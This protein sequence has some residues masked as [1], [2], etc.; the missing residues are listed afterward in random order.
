MKVAVAAAAALASSVALADPPTKADL[1]ACAAGKG[2]VC[3]DA[4]E[5]FLNDAKDE[6]KALEYYLK[7]C[8]LKVGKGCG[9]AG[10]MTVLGQGTS[11]DAKAGRTLREKAC[12][13]DDG[14]SCNDLG[15]S[16]SEGKDGAD[17]ID[18]VK[19]KGFY[20]KACKLKD[21]LGCFNLGNVFRVGEGVKIDLK[22]AFDNF[23]KSCDLDTAKGCTE[24]AIMYY[25]GKNVAKDKSK[26][27]ELLDKACK[28]GS[29]VACQ[30][31]KAVRG[32]Q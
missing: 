3:L 25:E 7:A 21:G 11:A 1:D 22:V 6:A 19:A 12:G 26:A 24:L 18:Y 27:L 5:R 32:Q 14:S 20:D 9:Y 23:K 2:S 4:G 15:V 17:G 8:T 10:T 28:L 31:A 30:N 16:W 29:D 13:L